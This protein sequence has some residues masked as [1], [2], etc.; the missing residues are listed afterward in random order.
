MQAAGLTTEQQRIRARGIGASEVA[1]LVGLDPYRTPIDIWRAKVEGHRTGDTQ[2]TRRGRYLE[3]AIRRWYSD[4][5][6]RL[7]TT[8]GTLT[9]PDAPHVLASPDGLVLAGAR[10][11][12]VLEIKAPSWRTA[13]EWQEDGVPDRYVAQVTQQMAVCGLARADVAAYVDEQLVITTLDYDPELGAS[14][15]E[16]C[17]RFWCNHVETGV[18]PEPDGS[19]SY[20]EWLK[21]RFVAT[22]GE[23]IEATPEA[24]EWARQLLDAKA[25]LK[26]VEDAEREARNR[27][28]ALIGDADGLAGAFGRISWKH[29]KPSSKTDWEA[30]AREL[31]AT[32]EVISKHTSSKPG[33]RVFRVTAAKEQ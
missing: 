14:L 25:Q 30:V 24:E 9:H 33:P 2:H 15:V 16:A 23:I 19:E 22:R 7:V 6:G 21:G 20:S 12:R 29:N 31:G 13:R 11:D 1:A 4:E 17:E 27:L 5:T 32:D 10:P 26:A 28:Q 18:P 8:V 3:E